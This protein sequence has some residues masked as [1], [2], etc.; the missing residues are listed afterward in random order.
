MRVDKVEDERIYYVCKNCGR[1]KIVNIQEIE[2][3][4]NKYNEDI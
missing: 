2:K 3:N 4:K 1:E